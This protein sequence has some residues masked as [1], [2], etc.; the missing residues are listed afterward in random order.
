MANRILNQTGWQSRVR[1]KM[2]VDIAYLPDSAIQQP[3]IISVA[4]ANIIVQITDYGSLTD[5]KLVYLEASIVCECAVLL[6]PSM[7]VRL[8]VKE[9]GPHESHE[10]TVDWN[11]KK[12]EFE[13]E[14]DGYLGKILPGNYIS[15][16]H[17]GVSHPRR[18]S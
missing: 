6:C 14:R 10:L 2:G 3:E 12:S 7:S 4:E 11:K 13:A 17:F 1:D 16:S 8:P 5:D 18:C 9:S 15:P